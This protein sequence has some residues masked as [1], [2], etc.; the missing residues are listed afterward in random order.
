MFVFVYF[1]TLED[2][3]RP[4]I[5]LKEAHKRPKMPKMGPKEVQ[6][7]SKRDLKKAQKRPERGPEN[8]QKRPKRPRLCPKMTKRRSERGQ[9]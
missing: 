2:L 7:R 4:M 3:N 1:G 9:K 6:N 8:A 5:G